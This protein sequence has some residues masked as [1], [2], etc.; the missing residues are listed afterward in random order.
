MMATSTTSPPPDNKP[1]SNGKQQKGSLIMTSLS[2]ALDPALSVALRDNKPSMDD[3][4]KMRLPELLEPRNGGGVS[5]GKRERKKK[6]TSRSDDD[7]P[8]PTSPTTLSSRRLSPLFRKKKLKSRPMDGKIKSASSSPT[9][10]DLRS[11]TPVLQV[12][13]T[14]PVDSLPGQPA[15]QQPL[16]IILVSPDQEECSLIRKTSQCSHLS[17]ASSTLTS[18][19]LSKLNVAIGNEY[20]YQGNL[21]SM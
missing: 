15:A 13:E 6:F 11:V 7:S 14:T 4:K 12:V 2:Q 20:C 5:D 18:G 3:S 16:P 21:S 9:L 8:S 19:A 10:N 1:V 17:G